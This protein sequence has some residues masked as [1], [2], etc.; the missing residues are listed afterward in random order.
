M[1]HRKKRHS[2]YHQREIYNDLKRDVSNDMF[3]H[4]L[5]LEKTRFNVALMHSVLFHLINRGDTKKELWF[6]LNSVDARFNPLEFAMVTSLTLEHDMNV[7]A[8]VDCSGD[9]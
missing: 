8:W 2:E 6:K 5:R 9:F 4:F 1:L 7:S 3:W